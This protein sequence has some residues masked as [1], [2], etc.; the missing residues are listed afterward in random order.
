MS[1]SVL[2]PSN[3]GSYNPTKIRE[4]AS[5]D[6]PAD[7]RYFPDGLRTSGQHPALEDKIFPY[8]AFPKVIT[9]PTVWTR[10]DYQNHPDR[11][12]HPFST[13]E[14]EELSA[15]S[16]SFIAQELPLTGMTRVRKY[17]VFWLLPPDLSLRTC[18]LSLLSDHSLT[19]SAPNSWME[20]ASSSSR[21]FPS[22]SGPT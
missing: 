11:W 10:D 12:T 18:S 21:T 7:R 13:E 5:P 22:I 14:I 16:D 1:P 15:A 8:E 9:G 20:E 2:P 4:V 3:V 19:N 17:D 6:P